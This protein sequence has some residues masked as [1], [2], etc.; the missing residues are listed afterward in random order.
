MIRILFGIY[1]ISVFA[2]TYDFTDGRHNLGIK[3]LTGIPQNITE[4]GQ[5]LIFN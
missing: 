2:T 4:S 3:L 1:R 5:Y